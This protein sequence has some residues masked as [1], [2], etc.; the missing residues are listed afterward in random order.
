[1]NNRYEF[2]AVSSRVR[3][4][5]N[6]VDFPFGVQ[7]VGN[8]P[9]VDVVTRTLKPLGDF[10]LIKICKESWKAAKDKVEKGIKS[11]NNAPFEYVDNRWGGTTYEGYKDL[12][13]KNPKKFE[14]LY[15]DLY[16]H[17]TDKEIQNIIYERKL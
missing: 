7:N 4:A 10:N 2:C 17:L 16:K 14:K 3:L 6:L 5:R 12:L 11:K 1:M 13:K 8:A 9:I 15:P